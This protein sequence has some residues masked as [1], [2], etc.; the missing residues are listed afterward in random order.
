MTATT[1]EAWPSPCDRQDD[2][3]CWRTATTVVTFPDAPDTPPLRLCGKH[4]AVFVRDAVQH[5]VDF[6]ATTHDGAGR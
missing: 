3:D 4:Y 2:R 6:H 1:D 5:G